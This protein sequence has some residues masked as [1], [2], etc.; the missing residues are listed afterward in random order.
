MMVSSMQKESPAP[1]RH[2]SFTFLP[3][4]N[5][6]CS[7][8]SKKCRLAPCLQAD[9]DHINQIP[10]IPTM[11]EVICRT[12]GMGFAA[13]ARVTEERWIACSVLDEISFGLEPDGELEIQT[14]I[15]NEIRD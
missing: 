6:N 3:I 2:S 14:T 11:L 13:I 9:I 4:H 1:E 10:I 7:T 8:P 12:T 5:H 15:C